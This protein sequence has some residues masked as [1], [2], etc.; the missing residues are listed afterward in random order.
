MKLT[1]LVRGHLLSVIFVYPSM[2]QEVRNVLQ[3]KCDV[4]SGVLEI[5]P[6]D[7]AALGRSTG[8]DFQQPN[9]QKFISIGSSKYHLAIGRLHD[10]CTLITRKFKISVNYAAPKSHGTC[11]GSPF[12]ILNVSSDGE[13]HIHGEV[14]HDCMNEVETW[15][16]FSEVKGWERCQRGGHNISSSSERFD[17][18]CSRF[19]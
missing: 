5:R 8:R 7:E 18:L 2:A 6:I 10:K 11:G 17:V 14:I 9:S 19:N 3:I 1:P 4:K 12:G 16:R 13:N 15:F